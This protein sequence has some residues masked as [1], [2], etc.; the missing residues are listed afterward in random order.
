MENLNL[1][2]VTISNKPLSSEQIK[3]LSALELLKEFLIAKQVLK[4]QKK[5]GKSDRMIGKWE[6]NVALLKAT[7]FSN[8]EK[9]EK[10]LSTVCFSEKQKLENEKFQ[11]FVEIFTKAKKQTPTTTVA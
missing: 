9:V 1:S 5:D 8:Y 11:E 6:K 7:I 4:L 10:V 2:T 3:N